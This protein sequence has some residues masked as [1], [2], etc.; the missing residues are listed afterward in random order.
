MLFSVEQE[1]VGR[2]EIRASL[3]MPAWE[4]NLLLVGINSNPV[5]FEKKGMV[6]GK[7]AIIKENFQKL[8]LANKA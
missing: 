1:F 8:S 5:P 2:D 4:V 7:R 6:T 3:K